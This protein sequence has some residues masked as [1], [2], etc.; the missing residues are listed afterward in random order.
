M[1]I[2]LATIQDAAAAIEGEVVRTPLLPA[3]RLSI[4]TGAD[5]WVKFEN[6][7]RTNAFKERGALT[8][9]LTLSAEE[10][11]RGVIAMS[12][13]NHAQALACHATR[14]GIPATIVMPTT[15]PHVKTAATRAYGAQVVLAGESVAEAQAEAY[16]IADAKNLVF[17]HPFDDPD[18]IRGQGTIALEILA[19]APDTEII[20]V[21]VGGGGLIS[22]VGIAAKA[23][24]PEI[25]IIGAETAFYPSMHNAL[26]GA[27]APCA[28][29]TLA[30]GIAV[31]TA[32]TLTREIVAKVVDEI[33]LLPE[34]S[35][36]TAVNAF[37]ELQKTVAEGAGAAGL[38]A[39][40]T[41]PDRFRGRRVTLV[42]SGG[43][44]DPR[45]LAS[46]ITRELAR[47]G[48]MVTIRM[49]IPDRPG[50]LGDISTLIGDLDGNILDVSHHRLFLDVPAKGASLDVTMETRD[51]DHAR[52]IIE[53]L[54]TRG[55]KVD[56]LK[57]A[58][59]S[60]R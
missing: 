28:G 3:P 6:Q 12:A 23:L 36:E 15:T 22:G 40:L 38:A 54:R 26:H 34:A 18:I 53:M 58:E 46:I 27:Q 50:V 25:E 33:I 13:G 52:Q 47:E 45:L 49:E 24:K 14:L 20:V 55:F 7:Q 4:L 39:L 32:G 21:P 41:H 59:T 56:W 8:K 11:A 29:N 48:R 17:V 57:V 10:R 31:A 30:E 16:R 19:D 51:S 2:T 1:Q 9:L 35:I 43:N 37:L 44:I 42:L 5:V 60:G